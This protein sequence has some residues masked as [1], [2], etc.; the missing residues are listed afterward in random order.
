MCKF[1]VYNE[2]AGNM[3]DNETIKNEDDKMKYHLVKESK[4]TC[5]I[6]E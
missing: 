6:R 2:A 3:F 5:I 1:I 4:N